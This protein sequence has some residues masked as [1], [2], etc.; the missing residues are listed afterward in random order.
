MMLTGKT[1][2]GTVLVLLYVLLAVL[3]IATSL[4][5]G[6]EGPGRLNGGQESSAT[7]GDEDYKPNSKVELRKMLTRLQYRVTQEEDTEP[8]FRN[9]YWDNKEKGTYF[10]IVCEKPLFSSETKFESG[11][12]WPS[13]WQP[14]AENAVGTKVDFKLVYPRTEVHCSRCKAHLG[15]VFNDGPAPT[16]LRFC[17]NSA[18]LNFIDAKKL[19]EKESTESKPASDKETPAKPE[20]QKDRLGSKD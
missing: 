20:S 6:D 8:A 19:A 12:G 2:M 14:I 15:H 13:F 4:A 17:M 9:L 5:R 10:C 3:A 16:G 7:E 11:T 1:W 18:S